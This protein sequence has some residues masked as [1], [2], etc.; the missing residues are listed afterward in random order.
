MAASC[1]NTDCM[2]Q[3]NVKGTIE[4]RHTMSCKYQP[5]HHVQQHNKSQVPQLV[6]ITRVGPQYLDCGGLVEAC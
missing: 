6:V 2:S 3:H 5:P 1:L 4:E